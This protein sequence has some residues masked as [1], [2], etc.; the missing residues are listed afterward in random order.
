[1]TPRNC[2]KA[3]VEASKERVYKNLEG[4]LPIDDLSVV[5]TPVLA[6]NLHGDP[7]RTVTLVKQFQEHKKEAQIRSFRIRELDSTKKP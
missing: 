4:M 5:A 2:L 3:T 1:M 6:T 7:L